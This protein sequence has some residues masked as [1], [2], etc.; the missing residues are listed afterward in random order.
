M[1]FKF[2]L[3]MTKNGVEEI[4]MTRVTELYPI[5]END[6]IKGISKLYTFYYFLEAAV[7]SSIQLFLGCSLKFVISSYLKTKF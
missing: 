4:V 5:N 2:S 7:K 1:I 3:D 6:Q